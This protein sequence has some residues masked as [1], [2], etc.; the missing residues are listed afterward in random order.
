MF[1][2]NISSIILIE[3]IALVCIAN[4]CAFFKTKTKQLNVSVPYKNIMG[5]VSSYFFSFFPSHHFFWT[6]CQKLFSERFI[7]RYQQRSD[8]DQVWPRSESFLW[9]SKNSSIRIISQV[10]IRDAY[11]TWHSLC[12]VTSIHSIQKCTRNSQKLGNKLVRPFSQCMAED[13]MVKTERNRVDK[14]KSLNKI[15]QEDVQVKKLIAAP[16]E[17]I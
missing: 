5:N 4:V 16:C 1:R 10:A 6:D 9:Q 3:T 12:T 17:A 11:G 2:P 8:Q 15:K 14:Q 13:S 7:I